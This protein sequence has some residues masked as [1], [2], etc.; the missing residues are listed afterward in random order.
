MSMA[1]RG[2][3]RLGLVRVWGALGLAL[4]LAACGSSSRRPEPVPLP[5]DPALLQVRQ[6]WSLTLG[7]MDL[8]LTLRA[9]DQ[10]LALASRDGQVALLDARSGELLWTVAL[11]QP[12]LAG[13]GH[14]GQ[15]VAVVTRDNE[16]VAL[17]EGKIL[18]RERLS[19]PSYTAPLVAGARVFV[20]GADR[21]VSAFDGASGRRLWTQT[22]S[23]EALVLRQPGLLMAV[24]DTLVAGLSGR[25]VGLQPGNG[26]TRWEVAVATPRG[27][28]EVERL[29]D[30]VAGAARQGDEVCVRAFQAA[31]ACVD[32]GRGVL[33]WSRAAAGVSGLAGDAQLV[34]GTEFDG[35]VQAW[36]RRD[37]ERAW[38]MGQL[39]FHRLGTPVVAAGLLV[40]GDEA[41][42]LH[43]FSPADG[44]LRTRL[45]LDGTAIAAAPVLTG[46][47]LVA[48]TRAGRVVGLR[49]Q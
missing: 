38:A 4:L 39:R 32:A 27:T 5:P 42:W 26:A 11:E 12:L 19:A 25:L 3:P 31:V 9:V 36:R 17:R 46:D 23:G 6:V 16:V 49:L 1:Q 14:D 21:S 33:L 37:G 13:A 34:F 2:V 24:G 48:V 45:Q 18:W 41:G 15:T 35:T 47:T 30:V 40:V 43:F 29:V 8:A 44:S 7:P 20:L 10:R 22:R 28:N